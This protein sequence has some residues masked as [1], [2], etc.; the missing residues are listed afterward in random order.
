MLVERFFSQS[1]ENW[2][3]GLPD[4]DMRRLGQFVALTGKNGAGKS[5]IL[6]RLKNYID[7][8]NSYLPNREVVKN[9]IVVLQ[10]VIQ[11]QPAHS[12]QRRGWEQELATLSSHIKA[13]NERLFVKPSDAI[14]VAV[15]FVPKQLNLSDPRDQAR[16]QIVGLYEQA[17]TPGFADFERRCLSYIQALQDRN[18]GGDSSTDNDSS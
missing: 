13:S 3:D 11:S 17:K 18:W 7:L 5:R 8:R 4:I 2:Q 1:D 14:V 15:H 9:R 6:N 16:K 12:E 10:Q